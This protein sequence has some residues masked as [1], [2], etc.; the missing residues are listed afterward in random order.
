MAGN[1]DF[2]GDGNITIADFDI[3]KANWRS[4]GNAVNENVDLTGPGGVPDGVVD[5]YDF[6]EFKQNLYPGGVSA[7]AEALASAVPEPSTAVLL[8]AA[9]P[10][11]LLLRPTQRKG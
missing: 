7:F 9:A 1:G 10:A 3:M 4:T 8:L 6:E 11:W 2:N 5:L